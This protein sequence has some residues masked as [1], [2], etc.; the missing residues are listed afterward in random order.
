[1][2][3]T[4][5]GA[6]ACSIGSGSESFLKG[7]YAFELTQGR[8]PVVGSVTAD[9]TGKITG[10]EEDLFFTNGVDATA[11]EYAVGPD[12]RGCLVLTSGGSTAAGGGI[13]LSFSFSLGSFNSSSIAT[14]GRISETTGRTGAG[15]I[16]LQDPT[17]FVASQ[18][19]GSHAMGLV[20]YDERK[21][22]GRVG[23]AG[24]FTP[25]GVSAISSG[26]LDINDAGTITSDSTS[27]P[28]G[29]F[30]CCDAN[31]RGLMI[32]QSLQGSGNPGIAF[33]IVSSGDMFLLSS[34]TSPTFQP[35]GGVGEAVAISSAVTFTQASL[36]GNSVLRETAQSA[37]GPVVD[38]A[39][40]SADGSATM[41]TTENVNHAGTFNSSSAALNYTVGANGRVTL[42]GGNMLPVLYLYG[43]NQGF[44]VGT[45][46]NVT[47]GIL[48]AQAVGPFSNALFTGAYVLGTENP[49]ASTVTTESGVL[50]ADGKGNAAGTVAQSNPTGLTQNQSLNLTYSF[51]ANGV[52]NV[53]SNTTAILISGNKLVFINNTS[54]N[55]TI[56]VVEK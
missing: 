35:I 13:A 28:E 50:T 54:A 3:T 24:T 6:L 48:E 27:S 49:S 29:T 33:Y 37:T 39:T 2:L 11:S 42:T 20:G 43:P 4:S 22:E 7:Q 34:N 17:S 1:M 25:G 16:R 36:N 18:F 15:V 55:P 56:T 23:M 10:G 26:T 44:L 53:G 52:G 31:G 30:N 12:G 51:P 46:P 9:G 38:I 45:D 41:T 19:K 8:P 40:I 5:T 21:G 14:A 32:L 47:F